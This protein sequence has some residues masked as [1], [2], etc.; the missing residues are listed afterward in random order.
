MSRTTPRNK[1]PLYVLLGLM[2]AGQALASAR[3]YYSGDWTN[4]FTADGYGWGTGGTSPGG[5]PG[6]SDTVGSCVGVGM[7]G[8]TVTLSTVAPLIRNFQFGRDESWYQIVN[9]G[10]VLTTTGSGGANS[11]VGSIGTACIGRMTV[12][13]G[14]QVIVTNVLFVGNNT[15]GFV[16]NDGGNI[17]VTSNLWVGNAANVVGA[18]YLKNGGILKVGGNIGLGT[19]NASTPSGGLVINHILGL[20][21]AGTAERPPPGSISSAS[22]AK[23]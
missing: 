17:L 3:Y 9:A 12:N 4:T 15:S 13:T 2:V 21:F 7:E 5:L 18:V 20:P 23:W 22:L 1:T 6:P 16:T 14:G 10:G 8:S 11:Y 19:I